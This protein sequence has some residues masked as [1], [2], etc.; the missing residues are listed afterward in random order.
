MNKREEIRVVGDG[1]LRGYIN[2]KD[3]ETAEADGVVRIWLRQGGVI[4]VPFHTLQKK[5]DGSYYV[6][7]SAEALKDI[8]LTDEDRSVLVVPVIEEEVEVYK[9]QV[10]TGRVRLTKNVSHHDE[11]I[12]EPL[13]HE[14]VEVERVP[15][16]K[17]LDSPAGVRFE[18]DTMIIPV[19]E[20]QVVVEKRWL[21]KEEVRVTKQ[22]TQMETSEHVTLR[23]QQVSVERLEPEDRLD[24]RTIR[25]D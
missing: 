24:E 25:P 7:L 15:V 12:E 18:G 3:L 14:S 4:S 20:E 5:D 16:N 13:L 8:D 9:R 19:M 22:R 21:L 17:V 10:T 2:P 23:E 6:P 1:D 11:V